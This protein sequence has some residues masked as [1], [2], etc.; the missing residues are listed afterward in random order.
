[1]LS[2]MAGV[3][4][5]N[6][7]IFGV[8]GTLLRAQMTEPEMEYVHSKP[9]FEQSAINVMPFL[10]HHQSHPDPNLLGRSWK[11]ISELLDCHPN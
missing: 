7:I 2:P 3:G 4:V 5:I 8:Y 9:S 10:S 11:W 6:A 1:M